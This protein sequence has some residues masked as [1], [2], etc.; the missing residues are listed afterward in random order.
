MLNSYTRQV[1][2]ALTHAVALLF[3]A[4]N[5]KQKCVQ[6]T[7]KPM[8]RT[9]VAQSP[10]TLFRVVLLLETTAEKAIQ[11]RIP[12]SRERIVVV[13]LDIQTA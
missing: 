4:F 3:W 1:V 7:E 10:L 9:E 5:N 11:L 12:R 2:D 8:E 6:C 13:S